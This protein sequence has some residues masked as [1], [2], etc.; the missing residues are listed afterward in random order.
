MKVGVILVL[1]LCACLGFLPGTSAREQ[2][3]TWARTAPIVPHT[4]LDPRL[5]IQTNPSWFDCE[6]DYQT[7][8]ARTFS[9]DMAGVAV[10][11][12]WAFIDR[13][14]RII[15]PPQYDMV[16]DFHDGVAPILIG[17]H[18]QY[19]DKQGNVI[20]DPP[21]EWLVYVFSEDLGVIGQNG[22]FGYIDPNGRVAIEPQFDWASPFHD[23]LAAVSFG[24][25]AGYIDYT[26]SFVINPRYFAARDFSDGLAIVIPDRN[27]GSGTQYVDKTGAVTIDISYSGLEFHG[28][29]TA[30]SDNND[31]WGYI[32][33][34]GRLVIGLQFSGTTTG[35]AFSSLPAT[36]F[37]DG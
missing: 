37:S 8:G 7:P 10:G 35:A 20:A 4:L 14:D 2:S 33:Q 27:Q 29:R 22:K 6:W 5:L 12:K 18:A 13:T 34:Q 28:G 23:D 26:G 16:G 32:D 17:D 25:H 30:V 24:N 9:E 31:N 21:L 3:V 11:D 19:I 15:I 36:D 1:G